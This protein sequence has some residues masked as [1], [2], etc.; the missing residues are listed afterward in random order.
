[1]D[2]LI[3]IC[4]SEQYCP[5]E[6]QK[7]ECFVIFFQIYNSNLKDLQIE[8][9]VPITKKH[10]ITLSSIDDLEFGASCSELKR[11]LMV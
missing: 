1:M 9:W 4:V 8:E 7:E 10:V 2:V 5:K 3:S 6:K 11:V